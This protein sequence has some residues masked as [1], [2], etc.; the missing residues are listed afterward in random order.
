MHLSPP[1][2]ALLRDASLFLDFDGTLVE[3]AGTPDS[4]IVPE[5]LH[6]LIEQVAEALDGRLA[7]I[8]GR[9]IADLERHL[10]LEGRAV[11][12][13]H[14]LEVRFADGTTVPVAVPTSLPQALAEVQRF[15][16]EIP[17]LFVEPKAMGVTVHY[18]QVPEA[19]DA[20]VEH[21]EELARETGLHLQHGKMMVEL[22]APGADKGDAVR[23]FMREPPFAGTR[24]LFVG[25]DLTD[26]DAFETAAE[27]GGAGILV[28]EARQSHASWRLDG[29]EAVRDWLQRGIAAL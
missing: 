25:D 16:A 20:V 3:L 13:S 5:D 1:P 19:E 26:E 8:S 18:R 22:R 9:Y 27:L 15:A 24:P 11:A 2:P 23:A 10:D 17:G 28:G 7:L 29:V 6:S 14:G 21:M 4:I 12:G